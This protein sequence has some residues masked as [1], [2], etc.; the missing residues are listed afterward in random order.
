MFRLFG[1]LLV[2]LVLT[3]CQTMSLR[4]A[5]LENVENS[6]S[7]LQ[8]AASLAPT[9]SDNFRAKISSDYIKKYIRKQTPKAMAAALP[10]SCSYRYYW[11]NAS[12]T[13][14]AAAK[15]TAKCQ[16]A[17]TV[18]NKN[19]NKNCQCSVVAINNTFLYSD[20]AIYYSNLRP[21]IPFF[22]EVKST[23]GLVNFIRGDAIF[24]ELNR[25]KKRYNFTVRNKVGKTV[26][27]GVELVNDFKRGGLEISCFEGKIMGSGGY[28]SAGIDQT[29]RIA[30][31]TALI[32]LTDGSE[33]R[34]VYGKNAVKFD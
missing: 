7:A 3:G 33:M 27:T 17:F 19:L 32:K 31:G 11:S 4:H 28:V 34:V 24:E 26:C 29:L 10:A 30:N 8:A 20:S 21:E 22:A 9:M 1:L 23:S 14:N 13:A 6:F 2:G 5:S 15:A 25:N 12:S 18:Y 16:E